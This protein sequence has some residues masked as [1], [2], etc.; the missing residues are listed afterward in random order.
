M[1]AY[2]WVDDCGLTACTPGSAP[3]QMLGNEC[4]K[5]SP[6]IHIDV[7]C[8]YADMCFCVFAIYCFSEVHR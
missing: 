6:F 3:G 8:F 1:A 2:N 5:P 4:G 7:L